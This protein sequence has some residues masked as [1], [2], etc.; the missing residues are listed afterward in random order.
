MATL[1]S[2]I[3]A[4]CKYVGMVSYARWQEGIVHVGFFSDN[5]ARTFIHTYDPSKRFEDQPTT[6]SRKVQ[7]PNGVRS[8]FQW[9]YDF[10]YP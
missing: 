3:M 2:Q 1:A 8:Q 5:T 7:T 10:G 9:G 4:E 6:Y